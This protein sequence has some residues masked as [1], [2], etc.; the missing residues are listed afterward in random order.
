VQN[1]HDMKRSETP[2]APVLLFDC[3]LKDGRTERWATHKATVGGESYAARVLK[4]N[5]FEMRAGSEDG[6]DAAGRF[7][8]TLD[9]VDGYV[10]QLERAVGLKGAKLTVRMAFIEL[11]TGM[12]ATEPITVFLG[13]ANPPEEIAE[14]FGRV[15]FTSRLG[16]QR[17]TL[18]QLRIQP[19]CPW[20]FPA[21]A[22]QREEAANG[23]EEGAYSP[24]HGCG[25]SPDVVNGIGTGDAEGPYTGCGY[26]KTDCQARGMY[27]EDALA[28]PT[29]RFGGFQFLPP[30]AL[31]RAHGDREAAV[32]EA[33]DNRAKSN[34]VVPL[35][36]GTNWYQPPV[37]FARSDGNLTHCEVLLGSGEMSFVHKVVA[38]G[39]EIPAGETGKDMGATGW[40][41]VVSLGERNG[42]FNLNF[43][44]GTGKPI[45]DPHGSMAVVAVA[46]PNRVS[47][48][49]SIPKI[50]VLADGMRLER[51]GADGVAMGR[52][53]TRNP[54]WVILDVLR[55][56]GWKLGELNIESFAA[57]AMNCDELIE[58]QDS[59]GNARMAPKFEVNMALLKRKSAAEIV[60]G[61]RSSAAL[62]LTFG[63]DG[64]LQLTPED[65]IGRQQATKP[66]CSNSAEPLAGGWPAYE[67]G[68]GTGGTT[69]ILRRSNGEPA[70]RL[71]AR[72]TAESPNRWSVEFQNSFNEYQQDSVSL[73]DLDDV[74]AA[75][76]ELSATVPALGLPHFDQ[77]AR[78]TRFHLMKSLR[79][80]SYVEFDTGTHAL[81]LRPGDLISLTYLKEGLERSL[82]RIVK[83]SPSENYMTTRI[84]AQRHE[85]EW[86]E[87]LAGGWAETQERRRQNGR[88]GMA[89]RPI[90]GV[91]LDEHER[92]VFEVVEEL[93]DEAGN[94]VR[95]KVRYGKPDLAEASTASVP[96]VGL[97]PLVETTGGMLEGG[98][99][100]YYAVSALDGSL[101]ETEL[102]FVVRAS[103]PAGATN[104]VT[105]RE[106]SFAAGTAGF[107]VYRG[108]SPSRL[109]RIAQVGQAQAAFTDAGLAAQC[110]LPVDA[111]F[112]H[113]NFYWRTELMPE[114]AVAAASGTTLTGVGLS[115]TPNEFRSSVVRIT[116]GKGVGQERVVLGHDEDTFELQ[117]AW[118]TVPDGTSE[119]VVG[120]AAWRFG[121]ATRTDEAQFEVPNRPDVYV[122][123]SG[124][125]ANVQDSESD[126]EI[127][128]LHRHRVGGMAGGDSD[129]PPEPVFALAPATS[130]ELW[131]TGIGFETLENTTTVGSGTLVIRYADETGES[132]A[133]ALAG[134]VSAEEEWIALDPASSA[135]VGDLI[136]VDRELMR[137]IDVTP[138]GQVLRVERGVLKSTAVMHA[139]GAAAETLKRLVVVAPFQRDFFGSSASGSYALPITLKGARIGAA[140][141]YVTNRIGDSPTAVVCYTGFVDRGLRTFAGGQFTVQVEGDLAME[142]AVAP[143][144]VVEEN[145]SVA[146]VRATVAEAPVG[147]DIALR[148]R[149]NGL[150]YCDVSIANGN[151]MSPV[152]SGAALGRLLA[153]SEITLDVLSV[154]TGAGTR[155]GRNLTVT[156]R[157]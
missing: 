75:G 85:D 125:A 154:P 98:Q 108:T 90:T 128:P 67:F 129:T 38:N 29:A 139:M 83:M 109:L 101:K 155:P 138:G 135:T 12:P 47:N 149:V 140:E 3:Q 45:G 106:L 156:I 28:R 4:H 57:A 49:Q 80:N 52:A 25:Y 86:Y 17:V 74:L 51:F 40:Y 33:V 123:I 110:A 134:G 59:F 16:L 56:S 82:F 23:G 13:A 73:L 96:M 104:R 72:S 92:A 43:T 153:G 11:E 54:S 150:A 63:A 88:W 141:F 87:L 6:V 115:M 132:G 31:V 55:R 34:D 118:T 37:V 27:A 39:V 24:F 41:N 120:E 145:R 35:V 8:L 5:T 10:S 20:A 65:T 143:P 148:L 94:S 58:V 130:G 48:G 117:T 14:T 119:F 100:W 152:V 79:G 89:P 53:F 144:L 116:Q 68:D 44:D 22:A 15:S 66:E 26:T 93:A 147:G 99:S 78:V 111:N 62:M 103:V 97:T 76:Q 21:T 146:E 61:I 2:E 137:V 64:R 1:I 113:A 70:L 136:Q 131:L 91:S 133:V 18:P 77:A 32:S 42:G 7:V 114:T 46:I 84:V 50:E 69:G 81:G 121:A 60:R 112:D 127:S 102:S 36:Y 95:L 105:L 122:Q 142:T 157:L 9:N 126:A 124:R 107:R 19:R 30:S 71:W 151:R